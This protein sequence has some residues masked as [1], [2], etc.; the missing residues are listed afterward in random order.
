M[1][2]VKNNGLKDFCLVSFLFF[3]IIL[4]D[5]NADPGNF[6]CSSTYELGWNCPEGGCQFIVPLTFPEVCE[7]KGCLAQPILKCK[8]PP[9]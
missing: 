9:Q 2:K 4:A 6:Y 8:Y 5:V 1:E 7:V 3:I